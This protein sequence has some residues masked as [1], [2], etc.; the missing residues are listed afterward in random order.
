[1]HPLRAYPKTGDTI[2]TKIEVKENDEL[3][4]TREVGDELWE[5]VRPLIPPRHSHIKGRRLTAHNR[6]MFSTIVYV[7]RTSIRWN[8][9]PRK[10]GTSSTVYERFREWED[11]GFF[12]CVWQPE[13]QHDDELVVFDWN[14]QSGDSSTVKAAFA[15]AAVGLAP[16]DRGKQGTKQS[17]LCDRRGVPLV[18]WI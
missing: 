5:Q 9:L 14:W 6:Q 8:A 4:P 11:Q 17:I 7:L 15:Q 13:L 18:Y 2:E 10:L 1:M 12:Q 16:S 3:D